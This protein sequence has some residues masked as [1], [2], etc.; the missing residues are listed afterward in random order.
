MMMLVL[1]VLMSV[2]LELMLV[3]SVKVVVLTSN[4]PAMAVLP[5]AEVKVNLS[6]LISK[7][8]SMLHL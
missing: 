5:V 2:S 8:P 4:V 6:V 1:L 7:S 3:A